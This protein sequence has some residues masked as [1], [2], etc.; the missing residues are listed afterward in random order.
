MPPDH[1]SWSKQVPGAGGGRHLDGAVRAP[2]VGGLAS[3]T[4]LPPPQAPPW[5]R[6]I[7]RGS[8]S[9]PG[10]R[11]WGSSGRG[12]CCT[13]TWTGVRSDGTPPPR[14]PVR[15]GGGCP[16]AA[17][18]GPARAG[19]GLL[20]SW[21]WVGLTISGSR[22]LRTALTWSDRWEIIGEV[23]SVEQLRVF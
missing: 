15:N 1:H 13:R 16:V 22:L 7:T 17:L 20:L 4:D 18:L 6:H 14:A 9:F 19:E 3:L 23:V 11:R 21:P 10:T 5:A 12:T 2:M 8:R